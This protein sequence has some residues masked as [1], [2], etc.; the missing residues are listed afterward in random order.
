[1]NWRDF[2]TDAFNLIENKKMYYKKE[3]DDFLYKYKCNEN[4]LNIGHLL[5]RI[6]FY[7]PNTEMDWWKQFFREIYAFVRELNGK[8][9]KEILPYGNKLCNKLEN[10]EYVTSLENSHRALNNGLY[11]ITGGPGTGKT[12]INST[13]ACPLLFFI[14]SHSIILHNYNKKIT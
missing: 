6:Y 13:N 10:L 7:H 8:T 1:M 3:V 14:I 9:R 5:W 11:I 4:M 12:T 2:L